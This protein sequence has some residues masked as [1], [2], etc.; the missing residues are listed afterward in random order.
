[1]Q[2]YNARFCDAKALAPGDADNILDM[3]EGDLGQSG[4]HIALEVIIGKGTGTATSDLTVTLASGAAA[5][6]SDAATN[7]TFTIDKAKVTRGG[8]VYVTFLGIGLKR[9]HKLTFAGAAGV[10]GAT[11]TAG[12]AIHGGQTNMI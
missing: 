3:G 7:A 2:D 8:T 6:G 11:V 5:D 12:Y 9:Y 10:T 4:D 1:M